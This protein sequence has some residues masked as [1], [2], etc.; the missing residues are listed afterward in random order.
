MPSHR[1]PTFIDDL[2][3]VVIICFVARTFM[4]P[5]SSHQTQ[6]EPED[7]VHSDF[8]AIVAEAWA[9][10]LPSVDDYIAETHGVSRETE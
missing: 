8:D 9:Q 6:P 3:T 5:D 4:Q 2:A 7:E 1:R 10:P